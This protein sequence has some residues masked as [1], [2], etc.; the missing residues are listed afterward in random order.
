VQNADGCVHGLPLY[1]PAPQFIIATS[2]P[3]SQLGFEVRSV[4]PADLIPAATGDGRAG[5]R[6]DHGVRGFA[7]PLHRG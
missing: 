2:A 7:E 5:P 6:I 3:P 1:W 4:S